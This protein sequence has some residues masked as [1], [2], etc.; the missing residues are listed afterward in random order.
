[1][2]L[3]I[4]TNK[5]SVNKH[6]DNSLN[7]FNTNIFLPRGLK[8]IKQNNEYPITLLE[9]EYNLFKAV[10]K[11]QI[12]SEQYELFIV[13]NILKSIYENSNGQNFYF[14]KSYK[15]DG[16]I[17]KIKHFI[18]TLKSSG[19][20][21][22]NFKDIIIAKNQKFQEL[23][24]IYEEYE[25][26][27]EAKNLIDC[28][29]VKYK[30]L[31][32]TEQNIDNIYIL[33][34]I[35]KIILKNFYD[36]DAYYFT[37]FFNLSKFIDVEIHF[38]LPNSQKAKSY[39]FIDYNIKKFERLADEF[40][41]HKISLHFE[42]YKSH[43]D[44]EYI[45]ENL[46]T[47]P[48]KKIETNSNNII[49]IIECQNI[50]NEITFTAQ[51]IRTLINNNIPLNKIN[52]FIPDDDNYKIY[53]KNI[54]EKY[55]IPFYISADI[56]INQL[57]F[58][59]FL[60]NIYKMLKNGYIIKEFIDILKS[61]YFN[62]FIQNNIKQRII[63]HLIEKLSKQKIKKINLDIF[64]CLFSDCEQTII[65]KIPIII[66]ILDKINKSENLE[67]YIYSLKFLVEK[68]SIFTNE[69]DADSKNPNKKAYNKLIAELENIKILTDY[70]DAYKTMT[71]EEFYNLLIETVHNTKL[72]AP[73][74]TKNFLNI[75]SYKNAV[76]R[77]NDYVFAVGLNDTSF[78]IV[79]LE[80]ALL[81]DDEINALNKKIN[82]KYFNNN[83]AL[84]GKSEILKTSKIYSYE[85][86]FIFYSI[87]RAA[88]NK[89]FLIYSLTDNQNK[90]SNMSPYINE[91]LEIAN[92]SPKK[93]LKF[94]E[95]P[96][97]KTYKLDLLVYAF[98][99]LNNQKIAKHLKKI[100]VSN[101]KNNIEN[102]DLIIRKKNYEISRIKYFNNEYNLENE[103]NLKKSMIL[104]YNGL[105]SALNNNEKNMYSVTVT[106]LEKAANCMFNYF[107]ANILNLSK[108]AEFTE[109]LDN[110]D[111]GTLLHKI[112]E[113]FMKKINN[114]QFPEK[115]AIEEI[116]KNE[117]EEYYKSTSITDESTKKILKLTLQEYINNFYEYEA[118]NFKNNPYKNVETEYKLKNISIGNNLLFSITAKIDRLD[119]FENQIAVYDYKTAKEKTVKD[120]I[121]KK[122]YC[123]F[124]L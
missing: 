61:S 14:F 32:T 18:Y 111:M 70:L 63:N 112:L 94:S 78:P 57:P 1:M 71:I 26:I 80:N 8:N 74:I 49:E 10:N 65:E 34:N 123:V 42:E 91:I 84:F 50:Q 41:E 11:E 81:A 79:Y 59:Q 105:I 108:E 55:K 93:I 85:D 103:Y 33:Q 9:F 106:G 47:N 86:K 119:I 68:L 115:T 82:E 24:K 44:I 30:I 83:S 52:V 6:I 121:S 2:N 87:L 104:K 15:F 99:I 53:I 43:S 113:K 29:T 12:I 31:K 92:F 124:Y 25:K 107:C 89:I 75:L 35:D 88:Q 39:T 3:L 7:K 21:S 120:Y 46:F 118:T 101:L 110:S 109:T 23:S 4:F 73:K 122:N 20:D 58:I 76:G 13:K 19:I 66:E 117:L 72:E 69:N 40:Q 28:A 95:N 100:I 64:N 98:N 116:L 38:P 97:Y 45:C 77:N 102:I 22:K 62:N 60:I 90:I 56:T 27:L 37:L 48:R 16:F 51:N 96:D 114:Q 17:R 5:T 36:F 54:F 67:N